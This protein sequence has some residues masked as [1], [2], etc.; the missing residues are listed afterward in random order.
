MEAS[1]AISDEFLVPVTE[2]ADNA[3]TGPELALVLGSQAVEQTIERAP[4]ILA[5]TE[6]DFREFVH[7]LSQTGQ[8]R[9]EAA[10]LQALVSI[11]EYL[12]NRK[13]YLS[14]VLATLT[15]QAS[16]MSTI[17]NTDYQFLAW[18]RGYIKDREDPAEA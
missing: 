2:S 18:V 12:V 4:D 6:P 14:H 9:D 13:E 16:E 15:V 3:E 1:R 8:D 10:V 5:M 7:A 17:L 11:E